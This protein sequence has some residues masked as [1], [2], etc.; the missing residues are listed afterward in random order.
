MPVSEKTF[1]KIK[2]HAARGDDPDSL[3]L[4]DIEG[5]NLAA[6]WDPLV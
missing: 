3:K 5:T 1:K 4:E 6:I 2:F